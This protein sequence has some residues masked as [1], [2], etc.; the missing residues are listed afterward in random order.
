LKTVSTA[1]CGDRDLSAPPFHGRL[2][3][4]GPSAGRKTA[5]YAKAYGHRALSLPPFMEGQPGRRRAPV[6]SGMDGQP[7]GGGSRPR[8]STNCR[9]AR[10]WRTRRRGDDKP[11]TV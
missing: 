7:L 4:Q 3:G 1:T 8:P 11:D 2:T 5:R 6:R 10:R 9:A